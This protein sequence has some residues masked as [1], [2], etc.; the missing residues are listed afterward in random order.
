MISR[1]Y[2]QSFI[3]GYIVSYFG[4]NN[5]TIRDKC[6]TVYGYVHVVAINVALQRKRLLLKC[7]TTRG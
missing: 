4:A 6:T 1:K 2:W 3:C 7:D 5:L